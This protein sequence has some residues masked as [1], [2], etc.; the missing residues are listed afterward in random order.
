MEDRPLT[1]EAK[2][3]TPGPQEYN[4]D[5]IIGFKGVRVSIGKDS[6]EA[7]HIRK[8]KND[9]SPGPLAYTPRV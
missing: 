4:I 5:P 6:R 9:R 3:V 8:A 2:A 1:R 7:L